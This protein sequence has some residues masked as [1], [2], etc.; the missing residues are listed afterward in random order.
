MSLF[1]NLV[2]F[3]LVGYTVGMIDVYTTFRFHLLLWFV[4]D[5]KVN[6]EYFSR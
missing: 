6:L 4:V 1:C 3:A 5:V 2:S